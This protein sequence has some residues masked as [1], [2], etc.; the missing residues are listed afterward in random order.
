[1]NPKLWVALSGGRVVV[2]DAASWSMQQDCLQI[3]E[4]QVVR[5]DLFHTY[6]SKCFSNNAAYVGMNS[7]M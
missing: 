2:F 7:N 4:A 1:M 5:A 6:L 3:G